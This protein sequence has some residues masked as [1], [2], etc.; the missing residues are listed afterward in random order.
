MHQVTGA[1]MV[2]AEDV[3]LSVFSNLAQVWDHVQ[4]KYDLCRKGH[5]IIDELSTNKLLNTCFVSLI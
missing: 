2:T 5:L 4:W 1:W 3:T